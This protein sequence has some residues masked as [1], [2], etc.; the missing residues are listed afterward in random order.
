MRTGSCTTCCLN[1][2]LFLFWGFF[3][4][5]GTC[6]KLEELRAER[7]PCVTSPFCVSRLSHRLFECSLP[8]LSSLLSFSRLSYY[9]R[10]DFSSVWSSR[11][12]AA[13]SFSIS[14]SISLIWSSSWLG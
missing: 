11:S 14:S 12:D 8:E 2:L 5:C 3:G 7:L 4:Y 1:R 10:R 6:R 13:F 9:K